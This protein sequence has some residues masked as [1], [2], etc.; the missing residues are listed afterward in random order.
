ML[1]F[2]YYLSIQKLSSD[3][4]SI[5]LITFNTKYAESNQSLLYNTQIFRYINN[6][7]C[8]FDM[9]IADDTSLSA[10]LPRDRCIFIALWKKKQKLEYYGIMDQPQWKQMHS[11]VECNHMNE[12]WKIKP[13]IKYNKVFKSGPS[14]IC[15]RQSLKNFLNTFFQIVLTQLD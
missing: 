11:L 4:P 9:W 13:S 8:Y 5:F 10:N 12:V 1:Q 6:K 2:F 15:G 7:C 14:K 3:F